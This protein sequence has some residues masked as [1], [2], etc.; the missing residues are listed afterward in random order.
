MTSAWPPGKWKR[1]GACQQDSFSFLHFLQ[2]PAPAAPM[3]A[4]QL[5]LDT[6]LSCTPPCTFVSAAGGP[7]S[8]WLLAYWSKAHFLSPAK[9]LALETR[10]QRG[11]K[12]PMGKESK[13]FVELPM[14][15]V[16]Q[17]LFFWE[18]SS[19]WKVGLCYS[20]WAKA[21]NN[22]HKVHSFNL[23]CRLIATI[24]L[25]LSYKTG[26]FIWFHLLYH[27]SSVLGTEDKNN[28]TKRRSFK[29]HSIHKGDGHWSRWL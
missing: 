11:L 6:L 13:V 28:N 29:E 20:L 9:A 14:K 27:F 25:F 18:S 16:G 23:V 19:F 2:P 26:S 5:G 22:I 21:W 12:K 10:T 3:A 1:G 4:F 15:N 8:L 24:Q 17:Y 7:R